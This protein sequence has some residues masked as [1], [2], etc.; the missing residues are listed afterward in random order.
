MSDKRAKF[1]LIRSTA[2][3]RVMS[4]V[5]SEMLPDLPAGWQI[6]TGAI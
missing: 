6:L 3:R 2:E 5:T 1:L 4:S